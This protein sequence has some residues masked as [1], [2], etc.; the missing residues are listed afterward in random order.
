VQIGRIREG[1]GQLEE[2]ERAAG[3]IGDGGLA[4]SIRISQLVYRAQFGLRPE[5]DLR[6]LEAALVRLDPQNS[7]AQANLLLEIAN[8][9]LLRG[10]L[11]E[12]SQALSEASTRIYRSRHLRYGNQLSLRLAELSYRSGQSASALHSVK[13]VLS[14]LDERHDR[15]LLLM[16][17]GLELKLVREL[18]MTDSEEEVRVRLDRLTRATPRA[19]SR[20]ILARAGLRGGG[21]SASQATHEDLLGSFLD[22][23]RKDPRGQLRKLLSMGYLELLPEALGVPRAGC[24]LVFGILGQDCAILERGEAVYRGKG[25]TQQMTALLTALG[26]GE[27]SKADLVRAIWG[28]QYHPL[29]HDPLIFQAVSR[30][31]ELLGSR[32][33]WVES[34]ATGYRL[35]PE[36]RVV[37]LRSEER[38]PEPSWARASAPARAGLASGDLNFRQ[39]RILEL[40]KKSRF[41]A[42]SDC[43]RKFR[44]TEMT[45]RRDFAALMKAGWIARTGRARAT[46]YELRRNFE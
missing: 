5:R 39:V 28:Y 12:A 13:S 24:S 34:T 3:R 27:R 9:L 30:V 19:V 11:A 36:V 14:S 6:D 23:F 17:L 38:S 40:M 10:R 4:R 1:L 46:R 22:A 15:V 7:H 32:S 29:R 21:D 37:S 41:L 25:V 18:G 31:R 43:A 42:A 33:H 16:A 20:A 8:Q 26:Q 44:V 45:A 35:W 2:A